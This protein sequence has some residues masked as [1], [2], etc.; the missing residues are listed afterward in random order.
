[1]TEW[2]SRVGI[3]VSE[4]KRAIDEHVE[5]QAL[6]KAYCLAYPTVRETDGVDCSD[7]PF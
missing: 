2:G 6:W 4:A 3:P 1:M 5:R 7:E